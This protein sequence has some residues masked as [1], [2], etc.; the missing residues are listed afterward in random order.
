MNKK[1]LALFY[2]ELSQ[3]TTSIPLVNSL[4]ALQSHAPLSMRKIVVSI[5]HHLQAGHT[6]SG[7][8]ALY[9]HYFPTLHIALI[10]M[11][12][13]SGQLPQVLSLLATWT[14][15]QEKLKQKLQRALFYPSITLV[16][17]ALTILFLVQSVLPHMA[18]LYEQFHQPLPPATLWMMH[19]T[20]WIIKN[21]WTLFF[22][23]MGVTVSMI[24]L[25]RLSPLYKRWMYTALHYCPGLHTFQKL[26]GAYL[27]S[28]QLKLLTHQQLPL[29]QALELIQHSQRH[30][31]FQKKLQLVQQ[32][33]LSGALLSEALS[34]TRA[35]P[36]LLIHCVMTGEQTGKLST[37]LAFAEEY[38]AQQLHQLTQRYTQWLEPACLIMVSSIMAWIAY[39]FYQPLLH[40]PIF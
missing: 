34:T 24:L 25:L 11:A 20:H 9:P 26:Q 12:E 1:L 4:Q 28:V 31:V 22:F 8:L 2:S 23:F 7:A 5:R 19:S 15:Q 16:G 14:T 29:P 36:S 10:H 18:S 27:F 32:L 6:F 13:Q 33:I 30:P 40:L 37:M 21:V 3:L 35:F 39:C 17:A 38:Y